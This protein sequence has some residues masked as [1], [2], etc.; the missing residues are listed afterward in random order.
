MAVPRNI[1]AKIGRNL[2]RE[3]NHPLGM[4][5][6]KIAD[7][8]PGFTVEDNLDPVVTVRQ[9]FDELLVPADHVSRSPTDTYYV[10]EHH[11]LR[12]HTSA[13]QTELLRAGLREFLAIGDVYRR[14]TIDAT[15]YPVFHQVEGVRVGLASAEHAAE[16]LKRQLEHLVERL[17]GAV[18]KRWVDSY[19]PFTSPSWELEIDY[20]G[21]PLEVLGCGVIEP[22]VLRNA[23]VAGHGWAFGLGLERLAMVLYDIPD[24]R[25]FWSD[26]PRFHQQFRHGVDTQFQPFSKYPPCIKDLSVWGD[27]HLNDFC[28]VVRNVAGDLAESVTLID[29]FAHPETGRKSVCYRV[30][31][32]SMSR[33]LTNEEIND[34]QERVRE[35]TAKLGVELR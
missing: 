14:D 9:N 15:H 21:E 8:F 31:Y 6:R 3:P 4:I 10:N 35:G 5:A 2:H 27:L 34:L 23:G 7:C 13:H 33:V 19:F 24:I 25:L 26:D 11:V 29:E 16:D 28:E 17:F 12:T 30:T 1:A 22:G 32:R 18:E 20:R